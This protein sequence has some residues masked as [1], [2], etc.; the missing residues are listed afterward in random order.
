MLARKKL[1]GNLTLLTTSI[2]VIGT[3]QMVFTN[4]VMTTHVNR[5]IDR[6]S[7]NSTTIKGYKSANVVIRKE[8]IENHLL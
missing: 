7:M 3:P 8:D 1:S 2:E 5:T 4:L 6:P